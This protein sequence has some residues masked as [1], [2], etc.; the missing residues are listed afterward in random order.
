[1]RRNINAHMDDCPITPRLTTGL[2]EPVVSIEGNVVGHLCVGVEAEGCRSSGMRFGA[3]MVDQ[4]AT[5][6]AALS[7]RRHGDTFDQQV[8]YQGA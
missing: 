1:M 8:S 3:S 5:D 7:H 4:P 2:D 6:P